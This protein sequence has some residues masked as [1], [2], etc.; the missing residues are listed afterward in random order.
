MTD[1]DRRAEPS[2]ESD[3]AAGENFVFHSDG[4]ALVTGNGSYIA[5]LLLPGTLEVA[6]A[7]SPVARGKITAIRTEVADQMP[8]VVMTAT[9]ADI[10]KSVSEPLPWISRVLHAGIEESPET[11]HLPAYHLLPVESVNYQGELV[12]VAVAEDRY[13]AEDAVEL[14]EVEYDALTPILDPEAALAPGSEQLYDDVPG[15]VA[16]DGRYGATEEADPLFDQAPLVLRRRYRMNRSG[17]PPL[18]TGGVLAQFENRRLTV[19]STIQRP[20][21][22]RIA[23]ADILGLPA[24]RVRVIAPQNIGGGFGWKSPMYRETAVVAWLAM[25][26]ERPVRWIEDRTEAL[27][28]GIHERDQI[29][30]MVAAFDSDGRILGLKSEVIADV[31]S[32]MVDMYGVQPARR[33]ATLPFPYDIPWVGTHLRCVVTNKA[34]MGVNRPAGRMPAAWAIERLMDDAAWE[35]GVPPDRIRLMN[36][37]RE[38]PYKSPLGGSLTDSDYIGTTEKLL[39]VF[40]FEER[41][42]EARKLRAAGRRVG[43]GL[44][45]CVEI[46][47]PLTSR[48]GCIFYN[49]P[50][51]ASVSLRMYPDGSVSV[52]SGDAPQ[53]QM[54]HTTMAR[55][56]SEELGIDPASV[57]VYT[58]DTL[59]S[60]ITNSNTDVAS[61]CG[62]AARKLRV[63]LLAV[64]RHLL[65]VDSPDEA[66]ETRSG[67][68]R[69]VPDGR[70]IST[71]EVAWTTLMRP[72][73]LPE[74]TDPDL[75]VTSY[76]EAPYAPTSFAAHAAMVEVD[77]ELGKIRILSYGMVGDTGKVL[78]P[79]GLYS[80][81][82]G[83][84]ATG[85]SNTLCEAY[86]YDEE[87]QFVTSTMKDYPFLTIGEMPE[88][89]V[90]DHHDTPTPTTLYGH[91]RA[92]TEGVPTGAPPA[93]VNAIIDAYEG[94]VDITVVP[95][96]PGDLWHAVNH[97]EPRSGVRR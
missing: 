19:W 77:P 84:I 40:R 23:L 28:K 13:L 91:K 79:R 8:G 9:G 85:V 12:A 50:Q 45:A 2:A 60:P 20:H 62:V 32:L 95:L 35:L 70:S 18:E 55:V 24:A 78:N 80:A 3:G 92:I 39:R 58:G 51:Y 61:V 67:V 31:G 26:L 97:P 42:E 29:W 34:P 38:F 1:A 49:Q 74:G 17:A 7:R 66:F 65:A 76:V 64:A 87:G 52:M 72:F 71:R 27:A 14:I 81:I 82:L 43:V 93:I 36:F 59:L 11:F 75:A 86:V 56:V 63:K 25:Q 37:V 5:D 21:M 90:I 68:I 73:L 30:D 83:G 46:C 44:A 41:K 53:G 96:H 54:R 16:L 47:R 69:H 88:E 89:I 4:G 48:N 94:G 10:L 22:L 6:F 15:N 57:E 33:S